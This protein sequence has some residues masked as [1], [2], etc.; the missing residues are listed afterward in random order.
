LHHWLE[1]AGFEQ[2]EQR[3]HVIERWAPL[4][5]L[6]TEFYAQWLSY[7]AEIA[8]ERGVPVEDGAAW[9]EIALGGGRPFVRRS[10]FYICEMQVVARGTKPC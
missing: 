7:L 4:T 9:R 10:D 3:A 8:L 6:E 1:R 5:E 2:V